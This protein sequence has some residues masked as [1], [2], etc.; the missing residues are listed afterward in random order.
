[1]R[2]PQ[3]QIHFC[4]SVHFLNN[5]VHHVYSVYVC[6]RVCAWYVICAPPPG[7]SLCDSVSLRS[8][9]WSTYDQHRWEA[10]QAPDLGHSRSGVIPLYHTILLQRGSWCS[11]GLRYHKVSGVHTLVSVG[12]YW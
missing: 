9:V 10:D 8:G 2:K 1:M 12:M 4:I 6:L 3:I 7:F 11:T 5:C